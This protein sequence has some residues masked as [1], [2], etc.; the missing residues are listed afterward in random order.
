MRV[1]SSLS[2]RRRPF[3]LI[4]T[5]YPREAMTITF[6]NS[7]TPKD[8][9]SC[10]RRSQAGT[11]TKRRIFPFL[12]ECF[13]LERI[14]WPSMVTLVPAARP[15]VRMTPAGYLLQLNFVPELIVLGLILEPEWSPLAT[16]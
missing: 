16:L 15:I 6:V 12:L 14:F 4:L 13:T 9:C 5:L 11:P 7:K 2:V 8:M 3:L 10:G 1:A